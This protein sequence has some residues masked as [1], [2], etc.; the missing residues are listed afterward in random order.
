V[1]DGRLGVAATSFANGKCRKWAPETADKQANMG[2]SL[3]AGVQI[4]ASG[5]PLAIQL[6]SRPAAVDI[7]NEP[8]TG[9]MN[10]ISDSKHG[11]RARR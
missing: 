1:S 5:Y 7:A 10:A 9:K 3:A 2:D 11:G 4:S 6:A 8:T